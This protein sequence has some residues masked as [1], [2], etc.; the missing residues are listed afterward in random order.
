MAED[1]FTER[2]AKIRARFATNLPGRIDAIDRALPQLSGEGESVI[3]TLATI[4]RSAHEM[5]GIAP[6]VGFAATGK[7]ARCVERILLQ[8]LRD[9]RGL[10]DN[11]IANVRHELAALRAAAQADLQTDS[12][13]AV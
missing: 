2:L 5:C 7:A 8:P 3:A 13:G 12:T 9:K 4:H 11:E 1:L 10:S 6:T